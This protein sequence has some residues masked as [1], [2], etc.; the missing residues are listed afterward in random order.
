MNAVGA[1][2]NV[3]GR[4]AEGDFAPKFE[5]GWIDFVDVAG[6][7]G[8]DR[9]QRRVAHYFGG[10]A[11]DTDVA[12]YGEC[13]EIDGGDGAPFLIGDEGMAVKAISLL[14]SAG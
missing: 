3:K 8:P 6:G 1:Q 2:L 12:G 4:A 9:W 5:A 10:I 14:P 13:R 7:Q 11:F